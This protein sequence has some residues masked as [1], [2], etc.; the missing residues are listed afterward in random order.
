MPLELGTRHACQQAGGHVV[1]GPA[2][3]AADYGKHL[4][5]LLR[6]SSSSSGQAS[7]DVPRKCG[8]DIRDRLGRPRVESLGASRRPISPLFHIPTLVSTLLWLWP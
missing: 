1:H 4:Q 8:F 2:R 5:L 7:N 6:V 3:S